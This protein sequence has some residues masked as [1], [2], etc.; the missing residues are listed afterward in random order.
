[1]N[2]P[3]PPDPSRPDPTRVVFCQNCGK[4]LGAADRRV[5]G[6]AVFC[7]P[8]LADRLAGASAP[9]ASMPGSAP[10]IP[11]PPT[12]SIPGVPNPGLAALLGL[13][14]GVGAMYNGQYAK[15]IV[16]LVIFTVLVSLANQA[17]VLG[18]LVTGWICYQ[19][20][21]AYQTA[22]SRRDG[23]PLPNPFGLNDIGERM[24][25]GKGWSTA[26]SATPGPVAAAYAEPPSPPPGAYTPSAGA[27]AFTEAAATGARNPVASVWEAPRTAYGGS[28]DEVPPTPPPVTPYAPLPPDLNPNLAGANRF[29]AM[30]V[31]LIAL[32]TLFLVGN[33]GIFQGFPVQHLMPLVI[34]G[35]GVWFFVRRMTTAGQSLADDGSSTYRLRLLSALRGPVWIVLV[36]ILYFLADFHILGWD[37]SW[38][39]FIILA[40]VMAMLQRT[41]FFSPIPP[42]A[43]PY[44]TPASPVSPAYPAP[45]VSATPADTTTADRP[46]EA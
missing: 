37:R 17:N 44:A 13:I 22:R 39:L 35:L 41:A 16:H 30:A 5:V 43:S 46:G 18:I 27:T 4:P 3:P 23:L 6:Q 40:G 28:Y 9:A 36:G 32:G 33:I 7:E 24:G 2:A 38:P 12:P 19:V 15:G 21:D 25:F 10:G 11:Y 26:P 14:P 1:M 8:C 31:V 34:I 42:L 20:F 45:G 29:P